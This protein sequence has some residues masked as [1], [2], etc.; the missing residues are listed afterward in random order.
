MLSS[1]SVPC[2]VLRLMPASVFWVLFPASIGTYGGMEP[3]GDSKM[4]NKI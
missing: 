2:N 3:A 1:C 4:S